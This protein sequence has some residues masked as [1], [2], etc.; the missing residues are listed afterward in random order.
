MFTFYK[1][2][3]LRDV[4]GQ[5]DYKGLDLGQFIP[6]SQV[7][8]D[9]DNEFSVASI[10][11]DFPGHADVTQITEAE[12]MAYREAHVP[13]P[14]ASN[15]DLEN[16]QAELAETKQRLAD[17]EAANAELQKKVDEILTTIIPNLM[18]V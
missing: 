18:R 6:G 15:V 13:K 16:L 9:A 12:Y 3:N 1:V 14:V 8:N 4:F 7:Y 17:Q 5:Y 11:G 10:E 2:K